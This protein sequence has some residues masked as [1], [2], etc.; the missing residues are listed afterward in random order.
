MTMYRVIWVVE[1]EADSAQEA[2]GIAEQTQIWQA[3]HPLER[4]AF[5]VL[6]LE[7]DSDTVV[8]DLS[9]DHSTK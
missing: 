6:N 2:A 9:C 8:V 7:D 4:A 1:L 5:E 3:E